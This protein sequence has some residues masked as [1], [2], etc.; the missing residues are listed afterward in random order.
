MTKS[1]DKPVHLGL[2]QAVRL[3]CR[4]SKNPDDNLHWIEVVIPV[5]GPPLFVAARE[6][7]LVIGTCSDQSPVDILSRC[8]ENADQVQYLHKDSID[9]MVKMMPKGKAE[10]EQFLSGIR[11]VSSDDDRVLQLSHGAV[12]QSH[13]SLPPVST[14]KSIMTPPVD[15]MVGP[16]DVLLDHRVA[17]LM[18]KAAKLIDAPGVCFHGCAPNASQQGQNVKQYFSITNANENLSLVGIWMPLRHHRS[19]KEQ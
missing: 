1:I 10:R 18:V 5:D 4:E 6:P 12:R 2:L 7:A 3:F 15:A 17:T 9:L 14:F 19:W 16:T 13:P 8:W 11:L